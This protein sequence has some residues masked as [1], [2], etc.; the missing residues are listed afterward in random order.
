LSPTP[1]LAQA[2]RVRTLKVLHT[3]ADLDPQ[4][5]E[6]RLKLAEGYLKE[7]MEVEAGVAFREAAARLLEIGR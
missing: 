6:I 3:I 2:N 1:A 5:T 7:G 4:N